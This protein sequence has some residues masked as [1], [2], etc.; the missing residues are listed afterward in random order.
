MRGGQV[1]ARLD[2]DEATEPAVMRAA[3]GGVG[4]PEEEEA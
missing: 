3:F 1:V 4:E 2:G